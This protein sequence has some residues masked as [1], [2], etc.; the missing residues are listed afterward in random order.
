MFGLKSHPSSCHKPVLSTSTPTLETHVFQCTGSWS[1]CTL[2]QPCFSCEL[3]AMPC[4]RSQAVCQS[5]DE[6]SY[7]RQTALLGLTPRGQITTDNA[8]DFV[9]RVSLWSIS[10]MMRGYL[11]MDRPSCLLLLSACIHGS[12]RDQ[13]GLRCQEC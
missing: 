9:I 1:A 13:P 5:E 7:L 11:A 10:I 6:I 4:V 3:N 2:Q 12:W 8:Q